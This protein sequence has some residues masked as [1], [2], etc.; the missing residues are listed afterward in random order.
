VFAAIPTETSLSILGVLTFFYLVLVLFFLWLFRQLELKL[1]ALGLLTGVMAVWAA[2]LAGPEGAVQ[3][4]AGAEAGRAVLGG[5]G[6]LGRLAVLLVLAG[7]AVI[8]L[9]R[10]PSPTQAKEEAN[11]ANPV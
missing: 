7:L 5:E 3:F 9:T 8:L 2:L 10:W 1:I 6:V 11:R 4:R